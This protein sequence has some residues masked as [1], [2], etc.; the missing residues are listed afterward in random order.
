MLVTGLA[1]NAFFINFIFV[2]PGLQ[3]DIRP[4][5]ALPAN[6]TILMGTMTDKIEKKLKI[7]NVSV[8]E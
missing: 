1:R 4:R 3:T 7:K 6:I 8:I 5:A 2:Y